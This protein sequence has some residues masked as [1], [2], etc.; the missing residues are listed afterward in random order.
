MMDGIQ[1]QKK[2]GKFLYHLFRPMN[3]KMGIRYAH[4]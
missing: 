2:N 3:I 1:C 4:F